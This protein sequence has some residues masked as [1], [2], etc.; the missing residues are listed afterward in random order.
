MF[1]RVLVANRGEVALRVIRAC[2]LLGLETVA[3]HSKADAN[4]PYLRLANRT[5]CVGPAAPAKSYLSQPAILLAA[6]VTGADAI[7]PG[8][9]FLSENAEFAERVGSAGLVFIGPEPLHLRIMGDK[10][11]AKRAMR[12]VGLPCVPGVDRLLSSDAGELRRMAWQLGYP[13]MVKAAA[14]GGGRGMR[15]VR[16]EDE[17]ETAC[18]L[19]REEARHSFGEP[20]IFVEKFMER[21]RHIEIQVLC[22]KYGNV[23][24]LGDRDCSLQRR[25]QKVVEESPAHGISRRKVGDIAN[26]CLEVCRTIGYRGVGTFE[27]LY[28]DDAFYFIEMN[29]RLQVEHPVTEATTGID[30]VENQI[31]VARGEP[32]ALQQSDVQPRGH[33]IEFR[34]NA[35]TPF[36]FLPSPGRI[37]EWQMPG[38]VG[39][40]VDTHTTRDYVISPHYDSLIAKLIV[41]GPSRD[42]TIKRADAA[43]SEM[44]VNGVATNLPMLRELVRDTG[45]GVGGTDIHYL[46]TWLGTRVEPEQGTSNG[47]A[48]AAGRRGGGAQLPAAP[49]AYP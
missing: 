42:A 23:I 16:S 9:G 1:K 3:V 31:R 19:T 7:H 25:H 41:N 12:D 43:L 27:F 44:Q 26:K 47:V 37:A 13:L 29:P 11:A 18:D 33:A 4:A 20:G 8:Y 48:A 36:T 5:L 32:L 45:F 17:L 6:E 14:G 21:P 34:I 39:I 2:R 46:E 35:E 28:Q 22:D 10:L 24:W 38:G 40:R 49:A 30:I 15:I